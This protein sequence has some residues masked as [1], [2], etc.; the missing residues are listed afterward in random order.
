MIIL[1]RPVAYGGNA[2][3]YAMEK[4]DATV[5]KVNHMPDYRCHRN[6]VSDEASLP[7][8]STGQDCWAKVGT[9]HDHVCTLPIQGRVR[10]LY[11]G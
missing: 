3:R 5:V 11:L 1:A 2:A 7:V 9:L 10:E 6:L 4:E 8:A